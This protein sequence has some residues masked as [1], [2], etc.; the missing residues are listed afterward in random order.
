MK[1]LGITGGVGAGKSTILAYLEERYRAR[2]IQADEVGKML[3]EPGQPCY[4]RIAQEFGQEILK[5]A[6]SIDRKKLAAAVFTDEKKLELLNR[7][8]HPAVKAYIME[9]LENEKRKGEVPFC[10]IEAA[11]L[12]EDRYDLICDEIWYVYTE[13]PVRMRRLA[14]SRGYSE[15]KSRQIMENQLKDEEYRAKCQFVI[16][17]SSD[18]VEHTY[19]QIDKG[20]T[21]H[22]L[23]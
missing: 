15:E 4:L 7:I 11:L 8:V 22:G 3:Q 6:G 18:F 19:E 12:L 10:V 1:I 2:V 21:E 16:D 9:E 20:L 13:I 23:L 14:R 5:P 17:N